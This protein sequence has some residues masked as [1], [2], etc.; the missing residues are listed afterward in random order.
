[1]FMFRAFYYPQNP[2]ALDLCPIRPGKSG[3]EIVGGFIGPML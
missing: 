2:F 3:I 1:M